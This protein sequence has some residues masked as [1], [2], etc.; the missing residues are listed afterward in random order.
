MELHFQKCSCK[1]NK[2]QLRLPI[3][4][5]CSTLIDYLYFS[6]LLTSQLISRGY[7]SFELRKISNMVANLDR[8][9]ILQ[10]KDRKINKNFIDSIFFQLAFSMNLPNIKQIISSSWSA[11]E[12]TTP[13]LDKYKL[14]IVNNMQPNVSSLLIHKLKCSPIIDFKYYKCSK[15]C[16]VCPYSD[17]SK[18]IYLNNFY[19]PIL[20]NSS[21]GSERVVYIILCNSCKSVYIGQTGKSV[22]V[23]MMQHLRTII[24]FKPF[25][26]NTTVAAHFNMT[27]HFYKENFK[28]FVFKKDLETRSRYD[29]ETQMIHLFMR[30]NVRLINDCIPDLKPTKT[31]IFS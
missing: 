27:G 18:Y 28:F 22:E 12:K 16:R 2:M 30:L 6:R 23:R 13:L 4:R 3:R 14:N 21:C 9:S 25:H 5:I 20:C 31:K 15:T 1:I 24:N 29:L 26:N 7:K 10:Y 17:P 11:V 8:S 19:C